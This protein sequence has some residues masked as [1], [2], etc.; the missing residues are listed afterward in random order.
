MSSS[1]LNDMI[2]TA[3]IR[4]DAVTR[5]RSHENFLTPMI[6]AESVPFITRMRRQSNEIVK[7]D[8]GAHTRA[9]VPAR[10]IRDFLKAYTIYDLPTA[11]DDL[12][13]WQIQYYI[14]QFEGPFT[15]WAI[16]V[17][18][19]DGTPLFLTTYKPSDWNGHTDVQTG[20]LS[21]GSRSFG[22]TKC[23]L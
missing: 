16:L 3:R 13:Q 19:S 6:T 15:G 10:A 8:A 17:V 21:N 22:L 1:N 14:C 11:R 7:T 23:G 2:K 12:P 4:K 18:L 9:N 20:R 5:K